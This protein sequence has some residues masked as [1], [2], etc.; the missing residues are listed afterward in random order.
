M[1]LSDENRQLTDL[2]NSLVWEPLSQKSLQVEFIDAKGTYNP[3]PDEVIQVTDTY[4][5]IVGVFMANAPKGW[6]TGA[7]A[8]QDFVFTP[9]TAIN[10]PRL[11]RIERKRVDLNRFNLLVFPKVAL[12]WTL[13]ISFPYWL[14]SLQLEAWRYL[15]QDKSL[16]DE[17]DE[18]KTVLGVLVEEMQ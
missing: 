11:T 15:G 13:R 10:Q 3:L 5:V 17:I 18:I 9:S 14:Q 8:S 4:T 16:L 7:F 1:A 6:Y 2:Q 12:P